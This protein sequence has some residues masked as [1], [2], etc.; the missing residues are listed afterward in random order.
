[1]FLLYQLISRLKFKLLKYLTTK[2]VNFVVG[3]P[4]NKEAD[5]DDEHY[6]NDEGNKTNENNKIEK[7]KI[8]VSR[9]LSRAGTQIQYESTFQILTSK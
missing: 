8:A 4:D 7:S 5:K 9:I 3:I 6:E 1:M 2:K